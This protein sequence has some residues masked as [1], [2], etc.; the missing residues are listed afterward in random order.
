MNDKQAEE[1]GKVI[2]KSLLEE[3]IEELAD[4][5]VDLGGALERGMNHDLEDERYNLAS[6]KVH[7]SV[8]ALPIP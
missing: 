2:T 6:E 3:L 5:A 4:S 8:Q 1:L 7:N